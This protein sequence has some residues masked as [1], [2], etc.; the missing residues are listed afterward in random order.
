MVWIVIVASVVVVIGVV[1]W[2]TITRQHPESASS[3]MPGSRR[4]STRSG[5]APARRTL[6]T[7][8]VDPMQRTCRRIRPAASPVQVGC[9]RP[10][11]PTNNDDLED[12]SVND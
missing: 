12:F 3:A 9:H 11:R 2:F 5:V 1:V 10:R 4:A 8:P 7:G 6:P